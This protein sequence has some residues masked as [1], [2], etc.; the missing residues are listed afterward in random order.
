ME[1]R[2]AEFISHSNKA[3]FATEVE[4][5]KNAPLM[6]NFFLPSDPEYDI[7]IIRI[8]PN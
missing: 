2:Y 6:H 7:F 3:K 1:K 4:E 8:I 5:T